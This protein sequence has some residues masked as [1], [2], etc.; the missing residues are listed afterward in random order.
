MHLPYDLQ[1]LTSIN[2]QNIAFISYKNIHLRKLVGKICCLQLR[3][4]KT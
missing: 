2:Y 3:F 1:L 4:L